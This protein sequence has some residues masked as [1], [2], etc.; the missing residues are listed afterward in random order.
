MYFVHFPKIN[1]ALQ[2]VNEQINVPYYVYMAMTLLVKISEVRERHQLSIHLS[3][4]DWIDWSVWHNKV[5]IYWD[6]NNSNV[7]ILFSVDIFIN[8]T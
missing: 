5:T 1:S 4:I 3:M 8:M 2:S 6:F 7:H